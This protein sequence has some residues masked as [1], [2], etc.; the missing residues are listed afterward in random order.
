MLEEYFQSCQIIGC[1][2]E[3]NLA[4]IASKISFKV[5]LK[6]LFDENILNVPYVIW[7]L[8]MPISTVGKGGW[9]EDVGEPCPTGS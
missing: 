3:F 5:K 1:L 7:E 6:D 9:E 8:K 2:L 4:A